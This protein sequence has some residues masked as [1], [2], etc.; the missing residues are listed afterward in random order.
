MKVRS[1]LKCRHAD[2]LYRCPLQ[3]VNEIC[4]CTIESLFKEQSEC[5]HT[6][7]EMLQ[8]NES[9]LTLKLKAMLLN[10]EWTKNLRQTDL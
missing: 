8:T 10:K 5:K 6:D 2:T 7:S 3:D 1:G 9:E 4:I